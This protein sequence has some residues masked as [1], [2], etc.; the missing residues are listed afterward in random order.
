MHNIRISAIL[1]GSSAALPLKIKTA[2]T[3]SE[4]GRVAV[5][6]DHKIN[7][8]SEQCELSSIAA[9]EGLLFAIPSANLVDI[10]FKNEHNPDSLFTAYLRFM[11]SLI[12][13]K[14]VEDVALGL[15]LLAII[16]RQIPVQLKGVTMRRFGINEMLAFQAREAEK[17]LAFLSKKQSV[18]TTD[19]RRFSSQ[20]VAPRE[21]KIK[22]LLSTGVVPCPKC[23]FADL[24]LTRHSSFNSHALIP[25]NKKQ[26]QENKRI[27]KINFVELHLRK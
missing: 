15:T 5:F 11:E 2:S 9:W 17:Q 20:H 14:D 26:I 25:R 16:M 21:Q 8:N 13:T 7:N 23:H 27:W 22:K 1:S 10:V 12:W 18:A 19:T 4:S 24:H 3:D 6:S